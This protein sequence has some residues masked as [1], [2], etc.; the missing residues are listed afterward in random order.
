MP[1]G[2]AFRTGLSKGSPDKRCEN[3]WSRGLK[4]SLLLTS[5]RLDRRL[6]WTPPI[7]MNTV[8]G[9]GQALAIRT[10]THCLSGE[11]QLKVGLVWLRSD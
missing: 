2:L 6:A 7:S 8:L 3:C 4:V 1:I 5:A 10:N 11:N 9:L